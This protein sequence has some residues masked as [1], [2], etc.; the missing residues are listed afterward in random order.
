MSLN[1]NLDSFQLASILQ[2]MHSDRKTGALQVREGERW[3]NVI[4]RDGAIVYAMASHQHYRLGN[5]LMARGAVTLEQLQQCLDEGKK[6]KQALGKVLVDRGYVSTSQ[7]MEFIRSQV[8]EILYSLFFWES[9]EFEYRDARL[10]LSGMVVTSLDILEVMLE[11]SRRIDE[12][13]ILKKQVTSEGMVFRK[14]VPAEEDKNLILIS[15]ESN[16]LELIDGERTVDRLIEE[17]GGDKFNVYKALYSLISSGLIEKVEQPEDKPVQPPGTGVEDY[18]P[19]ITAYHNIF[20][21]IWRNLE[22]EIGKAASVLFEECKP[23]AM[24]GQKALFNNLNMANPAPANVYAIDENL[25]TIDNVTNVRLFLVESLNRYVLNLLN[26]VPELL[27]VTLTR[28]MLVEIEKVLPYITRYVRDANVNSP[29][30]EDLKKIMARI[31][32]QIT[33]PPK[34]LSDSL[35]SMFKKK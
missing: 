31:K 7:L 32:Q 35:L 33:N 26:Q 2:L 28:N 27:G 15:Y 25:K 30:V 14:T 3:A 18:S 29:I 6:K 4:M 8:E 10:D 12:M 5:L 34:A 16:V 23:E 13:P 9:G 22:P 17:S 21:I 11:A 1:G 20:Q 24:P 19:V